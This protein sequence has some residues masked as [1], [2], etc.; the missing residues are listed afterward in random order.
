M[1]RKNRISL[2]AEE[3]F[4]TLINQVGTLGKTIT[5]KNETMAQAQVLRNDFYRY[6]QLLRTNGKTELADTADFIV[7]AF[8]DNHDV[9][10]IPRTGLKQTQGLRKA[11]GM[12]Q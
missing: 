6:R 7:A 1:A 9:N 11:L 10:F 3:E 12:D 5:V 8:G 2:F 4:N